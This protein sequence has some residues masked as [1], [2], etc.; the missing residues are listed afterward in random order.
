VKGPVK[1]REEGKG[2]ECVGAPDKRGRLAPSN[3]WAL[4]GYKVGTSRGQ[5]NWE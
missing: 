5:T 1:K 2:A 3:K 4:E